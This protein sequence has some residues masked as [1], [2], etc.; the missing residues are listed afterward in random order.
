[1]AAPM[2]M[3]YPIMIVAAVVVTG[4]AVTAY[5]MVVRRRSAAMRATHFSLTANTSL[6]RRHLPYALFLAALPVLLIGVGRPQANLKLPHIAGTVV[7]AFDVS[8]SMGADDVKPSRLAAAQQVANSFVAAQPDTV[9]I[10]VVIFGQDGLTIQQP[11]NDHSAVRA[12]IQRMDVS[13]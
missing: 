11:T 4:A 5:V 9:D 10:G 1:E 8:N 7:L 6:I 12:A 2:T 3:F 13:G